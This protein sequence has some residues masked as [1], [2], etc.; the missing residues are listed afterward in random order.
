MSTKLPRPPFTRSRPKL[1]FSFLIIFFPRPVPSSE[2]SAGLDSCVLWLQLLTRYCRGVQKT[3]PCV[4]SCGRLECLWAT[5]ETCYGNSSDLFESYRRCRYSGVWMECMLLLAFVTLTIWEWSDDLRS[6]K[7]GRK[8]CSQ[9]V[10]HTSSSF[11]VLVGKFIKM[12]QWTWAIPSV[13]ILLR[14]GMEVMDAWSV[15]NLGY[16]SVRCMN[17]CTYMLH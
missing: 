3:C 6:V 4:N 10:K 7:R 1:C 8:N 14:L 16:F 2:R 11:R 12:F 15:W 9:T 17:I 5:S 13:P